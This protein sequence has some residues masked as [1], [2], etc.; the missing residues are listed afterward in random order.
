M[1]PKKVAISFLTVLI[2]CVIIIISIIFYLIMVEQKGE[3]IYS[4][5]TDR[6]S[7][8]VGDN[9]FTENSNLLGEDFLANENILTDENIELSEEFLAKYPNI[10]FNVTGTDW[11]YDDDSDDMVINNIEPEPWKD[12]VTQEDLDNY[13]FKVLYEDMPENILEYINRG[14]EDFDKSLREYSYLNGFAA[15][16]EA[17]YS[18]YQFM[19]SNGTLIV[20]FDL[21]DYYE[22]VIGVLINLDDYSSNIFNA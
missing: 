15:A 2:V 7:N 17:K 12:T 9:D 1:S 3:N 11:N 22:N 13:K 8:S 20:F 21:N 16:S 14:F 6:T 5:E 19:N 10:D 18:Y 4:V